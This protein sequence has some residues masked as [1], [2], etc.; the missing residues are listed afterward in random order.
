MKCHAT[1][2]QW[3][4]LDSGVRVQ[5]VHAHQEHV[6]YCSECPAA[7]NRNTEIS[8]LTVIVDLAKESVLPRTGSHNKNAKLTH[9]A[10]ID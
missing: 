1:W 9:S 8:W 4:S 3:Q 5:G 7:Y 10:K 6:K 2:A